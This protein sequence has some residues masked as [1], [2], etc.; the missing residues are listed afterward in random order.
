MLFF[1]MRAF[2]G[3]TKK[4][5]MNLRQ[6]FRSLFVALCLLILLQVL[7]KFLGKVSENFDGTIGLEKVVDLVKCWIL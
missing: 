4:L 1:E 3:W 5:K 2:V 7:M 6:N